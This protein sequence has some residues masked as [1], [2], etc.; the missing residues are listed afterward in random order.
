[1][2]E[3]GTY[4]PHLTREEREW[5][6]RPVRKGA[7][8]FGA[9]SVSRKTGA[10]VKEKGRGKEKRRDRTWPNR[11]GGGKSTV[12]LAQKGERMKGILAIKGGVSVTA[13]NLERERGGGIPL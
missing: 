5:C 10:G 9:R 13:E 12:P 7:H 3:G 4:E 1:L 2:G 8:F 6:L 11:R